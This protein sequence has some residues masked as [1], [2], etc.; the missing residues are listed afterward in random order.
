M[1]VD[2]VAW[3]IRRLSESLEQSR[4]AAEKN[5]LL[6]ADVGYSQVELANT[7]RAQ[8]VATRE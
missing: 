5:P 7:S 8:T 2:A 4:V 3:R 1:L 6:L